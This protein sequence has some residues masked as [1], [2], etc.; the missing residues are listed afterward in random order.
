MVRFR[1][2]LGMTAIHK[3]FGQAFYKFAKDNLNITDVARLYQGLGM[4]SVA[5]ID[6]LLYRES[7]ALVNVMKLN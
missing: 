4:L 6:Y 5:R 7:S 3:R 1:H 2:F